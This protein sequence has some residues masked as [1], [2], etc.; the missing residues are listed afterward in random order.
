ME[1]RFSYRSAFFQMLDH[2]S[3]E[4]VRRHTAIP[5]SIRVHH[6]DRSIA[7][8]AEARRLPALDS[9]GSEEKILTL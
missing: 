4:Q 5:D 7:T 8:D 2:D 3:L 1:Y 6:D 9:V